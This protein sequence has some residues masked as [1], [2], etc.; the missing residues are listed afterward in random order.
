M[1]HR[2]DR[3]SYAAGWVAGAVT[4]YF[5]GRWLAARRSPQPVTSP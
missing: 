1:N 4:A 2:L 3:A 5:F